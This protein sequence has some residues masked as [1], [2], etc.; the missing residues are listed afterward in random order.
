MACRTTSRRNAGDVMTM[1]QLREEQELEDTTADRLDAVGVK[2]NKNGG[3]G[4]ATS[5]EFAIQCKNWANKI[6][7][8]VVD[9]LAGMLSKR[10]NCSKI[11]IVVAPFGYTSEAKKVGREQGIILTN[12]KDLC[13]DLFDKIAKKQKAKDRFI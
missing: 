9:E 1:R 3:P 10:D 11:S 4:E 6:G 8:Y 5:H 12:V 2:N 13:N 7:R